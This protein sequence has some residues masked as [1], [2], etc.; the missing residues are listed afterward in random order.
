MPGKGLRESLVGF[1]EGNTLTNS[2]I[3][4]PFREYRIQKSYKSLLELKELS[5]DKL[6]HWRERIYKVK[7]S[8]DNARISKVSGAGTL[9]KGYLRMHN[10]LI[11]H[12]LSYYGAPMLRLLMENESVHEPQEEYVFQEVLKLMKPGAT[13]L[14]LGCYWGFYSM[15]F[16]SKIPNAQ[17]YLIDNNDG[18]IRAKGNFNL[19]NLNANFMEGYIGK[20]NPASDIT[21]TNVD[22]IC[23]EKGIEFLDILHSDIE[24]FELEMLSTMPE[25]VAKRAIGYIFI[26]THSNELHYACLDWMEKNGYTVLCHSD[27]DKTFSQDGLIVAKD[28]SYPGPDNFDISQFE[29]NK[30]QS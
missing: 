2:L 9:Q 19:N 18:I 3:L 7:L 28:P 30:V 23:K 20:D 1:L 11:I 25:M 12:P 10:G 15:W 26:S 24:G 5:A 17:N 13:M 4:K 14:E 21:I 16:A 29:S 27:L 6:S 8:T 22:R